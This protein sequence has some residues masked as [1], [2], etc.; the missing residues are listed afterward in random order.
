[1]FSL[2]F[3]H[4]LRRF[5]RLTS[6]ICRFFT[7]RL[8]AFAIFQFL[9]SPYLHHLLSVF[10]YFTLFFP[11]LKVNIFLF[12]FLT[13]VWVVDGQVSINQSINIYFENVL[14]DIDIVMLMLVSSHFQD[15]H[16]QACFRDCPLCY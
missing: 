8:Y 11:F 16:R 14:I 3:T 5:L 9:C 4:F 2:R 10:V 6:R 15:S 7:F 13:I 1:M 12:F